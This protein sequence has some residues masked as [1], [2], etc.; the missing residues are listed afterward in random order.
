M[1]PARDKAKTMDELTS[2]I[3][4]AR[5]LREQAASPAIPVEQALKAISLA[6]YFEKLAADPIN[7]MFPGHRAA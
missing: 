1:A 6:E 2:Y 3:I 7:T 4:V 5:A